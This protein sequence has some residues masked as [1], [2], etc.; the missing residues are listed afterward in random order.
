[1]IFEN[2]II[3]VAII[4]LVLLIALFPLI[5]GWAQ[6]RKVIKPVEYFPPRGSSPMDMLIL[7]YGQNADPRKLFNPLMLYWAS[8]GFITIEEDCKRGLKLTKLKSLE[9]PENGDGFNPNTFALEQNLFGY[10]FEK[11]DEFYTLSASSD[12][13]EFYEKIMSGCKIQAERVS[14]DK[15]H[16]FSVLNNILSIFLVVAVTVIVGFS[17]QIGETNANIGIMGVMLFP[18]LALIFLRFAWKDGFKGKTSAKFMLIPFFAL[19]GGV[20]LIAVLCS[21]PLLASLMIGIAFAVSAFMMYLEPKLLDLRAD[22][23]LKDY[24]RI[25]GFKRFLLLAEIKQLEMLVEDDPEYYY[26]ILPYCYVLGITEKLRQKFDRI[27]MDG[28]GWYLGELRE[29]LMF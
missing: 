28:P 14:F 25:C 13:A 29:T 2:M 4:A 1:M 24:G 21:L 6:K 17:V 23:Q 20:P 5:K 22:E 27:I 15:T 12:F 8:R 18:I 16:K 11:R 7:Y 19:W 3:C 10:I 9:P 26:K